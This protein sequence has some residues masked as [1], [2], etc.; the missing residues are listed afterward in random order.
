MLREKFH[1]E[2]CIR[3]LSSVGALEVIPNAYADSARS[4][5]IVVPKSLAGNVNTLTP[6]SRN[7]LKWAGR[8]KAAKMADLSPYHARVSSESLCPTQRIC[9]EFGISI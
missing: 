9:V 3:Y 8:G 2:Q 4:S 6:S 5:Q 1:L 7:Q